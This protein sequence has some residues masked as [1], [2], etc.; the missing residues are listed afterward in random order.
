MTALFTCCQQA[1]N[2]LQRDDHEFINLLQ[3]TLAKI[4]PIQ[5]GR[6]GQIQEWVEDYAEAEP[7]HRHLSPL[8]GLYPGNLVLLGMQLAKAAR[9]TLGGD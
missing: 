1:A 8:F 6:Y 7:G 3:K 5:I 4:P 9:R 2:C